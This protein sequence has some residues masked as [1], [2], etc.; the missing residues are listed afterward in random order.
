MKILKIFFLNIFVFLS[1]QV[2]SQK[3]QH[4]KEWKS[5]RPD[6]HA[7][8][9][10]M[11]D[12]Y[13]HKGE[14]MFSYRF[15]YMNMEGLQK[16]TS[17]ISNMEAHKSGYMTTPLSM[18]MKM[19]MLGGMYA[20]TDKVTLIAMLNYT[21][22]NMDLQMRNMMSGKIIPFSTSSSGFGDL[23]VGMLY[24]F[25]NRNQQSF[26]AILNL[27][28]PTGSLSSKDFTPMS[29]ENKIQLPY[30]MQ[31]GSGTYDADLGLNYLGQR[32][33]ISWGSQVKATYR[34]GKNKY[35]YSLGNHYSLNSWVAVKTHKWLSFSAR[36]QGL[37]IGSINGKN[38]N[39]VPIMVTTADTVNSGGK[40][41]NLG[42]GFN[43]YAFKGTLKNIRLGA[44]FSTPLYQKLNGIQLK[45]REAIAIGLQYSL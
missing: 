6:G 29:K 39:L 25:I 14:F 34:F 40:F 12:H 41:I 17:P 30:P 43:L 11:G 20:P 9:S 35:N 21:Q 1:I 4:S 44:E 16:G 2:T 37:I 38:G 45:K 13:H 28:I 10:I 26:H 24:K 8:I 31:I 22:N 32:D 19:H 15:M 27:S 33:I 23:K 18:P 36:V 42:L 5:N 3:K 7:P